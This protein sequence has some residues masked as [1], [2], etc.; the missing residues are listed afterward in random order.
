VG[1]AVVGAAIGL[2]GALIATRVLGSLLYDV[3]PSDPAT[4]LGI[5]AVLVGAVLVASWVPA[6]RAARIEPT[7]AL[8]AE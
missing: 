7:E 3:K 1:V 4:F 6:R 8:R 5:V 2:A